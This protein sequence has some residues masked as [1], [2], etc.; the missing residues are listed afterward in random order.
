MDPR[1]GD[2]YIP[3]P[4]KIPKEE[5]RRSSSD[6]DHKRDRRRKPKIIQDIHPEDA[7]A[8][9]VVDSSPSNRS[10]SSRDSRKRDSGVHSMES[11]PRPI[12]YDQY[13]RETYGPSITVPT[14]AEHQQ[15]HKLTNKLQDLE[16]ENKILKE[17]AITA[18]EDELEAK[19][20][21]Q[22]EKRRSL[23]DK[24]ERDLSDKER[25]RERAL[26]DDRKRIGDV[27]STQPRAV[28]VVQP[29]PPV[30]FESAGNEAHN[31]AKEDFKKKRGGYH[32]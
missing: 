22:R 31:R 14:I 24:R 13:G 2:K 9:P 29:R 18:K 10:P 4:K 30:R 20:E 12:Y 6:E 16:F 17:K 7:R 21:L 23:L 25:D 27:P 11:S 1:V 28:V 3:L 19:E 8:Y 5:D 26:R 15:I 32:R